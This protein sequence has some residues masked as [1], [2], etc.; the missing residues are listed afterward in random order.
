MPSLERKLVSGLE[1]FGQGCV[2]CPC[3]E[4]L[5]VSVLLSMLLVLKGGRT[6]PGP[7]SFVHKLLNRVVDLTQ[8]L[9]NVDESASLSLKLFSALPHTWATSFSWS[10]GRTGVGIP[11]VMPG[12]EAG[13]TPFHVAREGEALTVH[14]G[15]EERKISPSWRNEALETLLKQRTGLCRTG[16]HPDGSLAGPVNFILQL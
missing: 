5:V 13:L 3:V 4:P 9:Q 2:L 10:E 12:Q 8:T 14:L 16:Q 7:W 11:L 15:L 1:L 6:C